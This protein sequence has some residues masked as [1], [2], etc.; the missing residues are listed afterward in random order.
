[1]IADFVQKVEW[2][3][4]AVKLWGDMAAFNF[5]VSTI[6]FHNNDNISIYNND[7]VNLMICYNRIDQHVVVIQPNHSNIMRPKS[8]IDRSTGKCALNSH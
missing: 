2:G 3:D 1:M 6:F 5:C 4:M 7:A 8:L